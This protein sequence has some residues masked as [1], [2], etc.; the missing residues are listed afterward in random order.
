MRKGL[1]T[2]TKQETKEGSKLL[3]LATFPVPKKA[4]THKH[5]HQ[6]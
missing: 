5:E 6:G 4:A 2:V 3:M 1:K